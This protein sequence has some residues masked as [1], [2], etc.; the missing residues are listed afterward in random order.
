MR[1]LLLLTPAIF[2]AACVDTTGLTST[3]HTDVHPSTS[4]N[5]LVTVTEY[6]D[7]EC[8]ACRSAHATLVQPLIAKYGTKIAYDFRHF[9]LTSIHRYAMESAEAAECAA[10]QGKFWDFVDHTY[11]N[12]G[13]LSSA[14]LREW[15]KELKLDEELFGRC[16]D[17][18]IK[19]KAIQ[20]SYDEGR[21]KGVQGTPTFFVNGQQT[22]ATIQELSAAIDAAL[23]Q[24]AVI[25]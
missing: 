2:L 17:S 8:P 18:H 16:L 9:P 24:A 3:I 1:K 6:A 5:A 21:A 10:D 23:D 20:A 22:N 15:A 4:Q 12:Q 13:D 19:R 14:A 7:L 25:R 11:E